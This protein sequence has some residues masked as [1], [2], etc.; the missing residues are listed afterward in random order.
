[1]IGFIA[2][3]TFTQFGTTGNYSAIT[4]PTYFPVHCR[5]CTRILSSLIV[6]WQRIYH[7]LTVTSNHMLGLLGTV[8]F[9]YCHF[10][11]CQFRRLN[12]TAVVYSIVLRATLLLLLLY[13]PFTLVKKCVYSCLAIDVLFC[14]F[15]FAGMCL[16]TRCLAVGIHVTIWSMCTACPA[17]EWWQ[18]ISI[19][20]NSL[21]FKRYNEHSPIPRHIFMPE[22]RILHNHCFKNF[23]SYITFFSW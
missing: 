11:S 9:L 16:S 15:A 3:I 20:K 12:L 22:D 10:C 5:T 7:T 21:N 18:F 8:Q 23:K 4:Y 19:V 14:T 13:T 2:P 17:G 6:F 1:M